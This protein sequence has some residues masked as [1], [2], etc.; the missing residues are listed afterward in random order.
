M[1][2]L[3]RY[4]R[5]SDYEPGTEKDMYGRV[6]RH[7]EDGLSLTKASMSRLMMFVLK[8]K[9]EIGEIYA[10]NPKYPRCQVLGSFRLREDQIEEFEKETGGKL[11]KPPKLVLN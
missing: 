10:F 11:R 5:G 9:I 4:D 8:N 7:C 3:N 6:W 1:T 2:A